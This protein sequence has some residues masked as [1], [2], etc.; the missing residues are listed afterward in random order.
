MQKGQEIVILFHC[1]F[2][3]AAVAVSGAS[4]AMDMGPSV[5]P[6][7]PPANAALPESAFRD[8]IQ[9]AWLVP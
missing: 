6:R 5:T 7:R 9:L 1:P 2:E 4:A 3:T 8:V